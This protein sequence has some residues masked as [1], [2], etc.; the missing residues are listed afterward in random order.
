MK[1]EVLICQHFYDPLPFG[2]CLTLLKKSRPA[3]EDEHQNHNTRTHMYFIDTVKP[4]EHH[5]GNLKH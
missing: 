3:T 1:D 2:I 4:I 5:T